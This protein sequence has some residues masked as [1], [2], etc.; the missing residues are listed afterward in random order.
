[1]NDAIA[2]SS[3]LALMCLMGMTAVIFPYATSLA[4]G[5][6]LRVLCRNTAPHSMPPSFLNFPY[7]ILSALRHCHARSHHHIITGALAAEKPE[8][9]VARGFFSRLR[10]TCSNGKEYQSC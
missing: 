2:V 4:A 1:M 9:R 7:D 3:H 5:A 10:R 6:T 8:I